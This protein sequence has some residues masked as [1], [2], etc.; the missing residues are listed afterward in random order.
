MNYE[1]EYRDDHIF[2]RCPFES[3]GNSEFESLEN[4]LDDVSSENVI[5]H[6]VAARNFRQPTQLKKIIDRFI[7]QDQSFI[8]IATLQLLDELELTTPSA[9][10]ENEAL[11]IL[12]M[13][14]IERKI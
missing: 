8:V 11:D 1:V 14:E 4:I 5:L 10:N 9:A 2:I 12:E 6:M 13:E 7:K 3:V